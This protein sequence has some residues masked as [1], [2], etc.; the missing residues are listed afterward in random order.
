[1]AYRETDRIR[2]RKAAQQATLL[3]DAEALVR[4]GGFEA[5]TMQALA[6]RSGVAVGTLYRYF[7]GKDDLACAVFCRATQREI[8]AV[9]AAM[10]KSDAPRTALEAGLRAF[11]ERALRAPRLAWALIAEPVA[12]AVDAARLRYRERWSDLYAGLLDAG[13]QHGHWPKQNGHLTA[14]AMVGALAEALVGP[15]SR[16]RQAP[17]HDSALIDD[18]ITFCVRATGAHR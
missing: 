2:E 6:D 15:L 11:A 3:M 4:E 7:N 14:A 12:P 10:G 18:L 13:M 8:A 17:L 5:L 16:A 1:M 9:D